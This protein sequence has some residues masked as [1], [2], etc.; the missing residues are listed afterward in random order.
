MWKTSTS[1]HQILILHVKEGEKNKKCQRSLKTIIE[2]LASNNKIQS[3][4]LY[5]A[6]FTHHT[7]MSRDITI[8]ALPNFAKVGAID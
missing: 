5:L 8:F 2:G 3:Q 7:Q 1:Y 4:Y 6:K